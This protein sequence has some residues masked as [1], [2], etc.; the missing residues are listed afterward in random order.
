MD[1]KV[2][3]RTVVSF[4][5]VLADIGG[6]DSML[7]SFVRAFLV[8]LNHN[9]FYNFISSRLFKIGDE[10]NP[11]NSPIKLKLSL[12]EVIANFFIDFLPRSL[13]CCKRS[14]K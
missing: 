9:S 5:D 11:Q 6:L 7:M 4:L 3:D 14:K 10:E 2:I 12:K 1:L 8:I 13:R